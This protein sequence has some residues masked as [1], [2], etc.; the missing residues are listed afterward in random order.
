MLPSNLN[1]SFA[2]VPECEIPRS[3]FLRKHTYKTTFDS[4]YLVP[5]YFDEVLPGDTFNFKATLFARLATPLTPIMDNLYLDTFYFYVPLRI[6]WSNFKKFMGEK[7]NPSDSTSYLCPVVTAPASGGFTVGSLYDYFGLPTG[8]GGITPTNFLGRAYNLIYNEWFRDQNLQNSAT[9]D[10]GDGP[11]DPSLYILRRRGKR[12][13]YFTSCLPWPQKGAGVALPLGTEAPVVTNGLQPTINGGGGTNRGLSTSPSIGVS[14]E[15]SSVLGGALTFGNQSGLKA[16]LSTASSA[17]INQLRQAFQLQKMF[18]KD[19]RGGTRYIERMKVHFGVTSP[20]A[21]VQRPEFL[22]GNST[23]V[24]INPVVQQSGTASGTTPQG[25]LAG[26]GSVTSHREGF[27]KSFTEHGVIIGIMSVRADLTYQ[28]GMHRM[29]SRRH[30]EEFYWPSLA[31]LG[32]QPVYNR[33]IYC[34]GTP[35]DSAVF[36]YQERWAE[37]RYAQS[38]ITGKFRSTYATPLDYWHLSQEFGSLPT[39]N[40]TFIEENPPISRVVA[41]PSEPQFLFDS[42]IECNTV[43][44]MPVYSV[45]GYIDHF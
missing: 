9:V 3:S 28:Q 5:F 35:A 1:Y 37:Y 12:H 30:P 4:G 13:D 20:D 8:V 40:T 19:A 23:P 43:R 39:L 6:I 32:E 33:E 16:D 26:Y 41:V 10:L 27:T 15:G 45:P 22:G 38:Y 42:F 25:T 29:H 14:Y 34:Q 11:D 21:R 2:N 18:E 44:P 7:T 31:H 36:G 24:M 17:T